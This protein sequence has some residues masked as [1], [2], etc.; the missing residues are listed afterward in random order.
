VLLVA[1]V[2]GLAVAAGGSGPAEPLGTPT[3]FTP[4]WSPDGEWIA[5]TDGDGAA[6]LW[7]VRPDGS[8]LRQLTTVG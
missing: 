4:D 5:F 3:A 1:G 6:D 2:D 8:G 7:I